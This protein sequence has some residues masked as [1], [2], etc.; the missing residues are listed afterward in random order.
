MNSIFK[1]L[2]DDLADLEMK[3]KLEHRECVVANCDEQLQS[4]QKLY[5]HIKKDH[6]ELYEQIDEY[7]LYFVIIHNF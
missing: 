3:K 4:R 5:R 1:P 7:V 6:S 2:V